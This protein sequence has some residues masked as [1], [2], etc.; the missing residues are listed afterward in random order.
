MFLWLMFFFV[1]LIWC[2]TLTSSFRQG[3]VCCHPL[4]LL[5]KNRNK[6]TPVASVIYQARHVL[7]GSAA[8]CF[9]RVLWCT[10][11]LL[12]AAAAHVYEC[13]TTFVVAWSRALLWWQKLKVSFFIKIPPNW[14][15]SLLKMLQSCA[16][17]QFSRRRFTLAVT[18]GTSTTG[19]CTDA[20]TC[21]VVGEFALP[22]QPSSLR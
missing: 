4:H 5:Q 13:S 2:P 16:A 6:I 7:F 17:L 18:S 9:L 11:Y 10:F 19:C 1:S 20:N 3:V 8:F 21:C 14:V 15:T 22:P 12:T